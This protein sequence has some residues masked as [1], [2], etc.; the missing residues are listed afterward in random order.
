MLRVSQFNADEHR[1]V[2]QVDPMVDARSLNLG[3]FDLP[4]RFAHQEQAKA[5]YA[6]GEEAVVFALL[7]QA[8]QLAEA[9][10][11]SVASST[12]SAMVPVYQKP[13]VKQRGHD[14]IITIISAIKIYRET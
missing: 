8:K 13:T 7:K 5:I 11:P 4:P 14:P 12:P 2:G 6:L 3:P 9:R 1:L 10:S